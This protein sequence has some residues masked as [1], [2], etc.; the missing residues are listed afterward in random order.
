MINLFK[1]SFG[2]LYIFKNVDKIIN[3]IPLKSLT[4]QTEQTKW[5]GGSIIFRIANAMSKF[6]LET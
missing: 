4:F 2:N 6:D 3:D 5:D 1:G